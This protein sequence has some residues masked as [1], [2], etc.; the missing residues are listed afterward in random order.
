M[1][2]WLAFGIGLFIGFCIGFL[3]YSVIK[4]GKDHDR[5]WIGYFEKLEEKDD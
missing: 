4:V 1:N 2:P 3:W 5:M